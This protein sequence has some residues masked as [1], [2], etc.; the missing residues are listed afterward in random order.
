[1]V[2]FSQ[3]LL[4]LSVEFRRAEMQA[5]FGGRVQ[6]PATE[7]CPPRRFVERFGLAMFPLPKLGQ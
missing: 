2:S 6:P 1:M 5:R 3:T 7:P 4:L